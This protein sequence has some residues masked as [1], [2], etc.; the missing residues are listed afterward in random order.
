VVEH[1]GH[2]GG[3]DLGGQRGEAG[4]VDLGV[5]GF[6]ASGVGQVADPEAKG[7]NGTDGVAAQR[8]LDVEAGVGERGLEQGAGGADGVVELAGDAAALLCRRR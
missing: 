6:G 8:D 3:V 7:A 4:E 1:V 2:G 5:A